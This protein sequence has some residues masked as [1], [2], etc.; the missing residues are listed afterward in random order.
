M[1]LNVIDYQFKTILHRQPLKIFRICIT[2]QYKTIVML[3]NCLLQITKYQY[4]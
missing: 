2:E 3:H 4:L 1:N